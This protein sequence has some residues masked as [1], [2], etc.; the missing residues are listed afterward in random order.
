M[1]QGETL[2]SVEVQK[3]EKNMAKLIVTVEAEKFDK[4]I[5]DSFKKN[6]NRF[7]IPGLEKDMLLRRLWRKCMV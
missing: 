2:M 6:K 1:K 5:A 3:L 7:N 4:A